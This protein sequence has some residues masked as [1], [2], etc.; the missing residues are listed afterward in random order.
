MSE[1]RQVRERYDLTIERIQPIVSE[2]TVAPVYQ[3]YFEKTAE[4]ILKIDGILNRIH[5]KKIEDCSLEE[6]KK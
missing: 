2:K 4:F 3:A 5:S 6:L 1:E